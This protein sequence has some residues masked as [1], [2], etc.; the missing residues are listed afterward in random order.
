[1]NQPSSHRTGSA[2]VVALG[3]VALVAALIFAS[4]QGAVFGLQQASSGRD[5][6][7]V[8]AALEAVLAR[9]EK[10]VIE[11]AEAGDPSAF[12]E[13]T[14]NYG[15]EYFGGC[16]VRWKVEPVRSA[17]KD[18]TGSII[19][20]ISNPSP[21]I[22]WGP[23]TTLKRTAD[24]SK[25]AWLTNDTVYLFR[26]AAEAR[27][28]TDDGSNKAIEGDTLARA[29]GARYVSVNKE[30]LFRYV[31][32]YAQKG[33]KGDLELS[34]GP[35]IKIF[36]NVHSNGSIYLGA[37]TETN[38]WGAVRSERMGA[39]IIGPMDWD[40]TTAYLV[41]D[42]VRYFDSG[43]GLYTSYIAKADNTNKVPPTSSA[44]WDLVKDARV[45]VTGVDGVFRL[46][47]PPMYSFFNGFPMTN[48][49][50]WAPSS[51]TTDHYLLNAPPFSTPLD[52]LDGSL[53]TRSSAT[54]NGGF[55]N[56]YRVA[57]ASMLI[58]APA[59]A[60]STL[61]DD[62]MRRINGTAITG[63][64]SAVDSGND[65]RDK[66]RTTKLWNPT[67]LNGPPDGFS[68]FVRTRLTGGQV[69]RL[70]EMLADRPTE[71]QMVVYPDATTFTGNRLTAF[72]E[73]GDE[74]TAALP[75]FVNSDTG[76]TYTTT[77]DN[78][79]VTNTRG[80]V[81][82]PGQY[83]RYA[84]GSDDFYFR[85]NYGTDASDTRSNAPS[86]HDL[87][88]GRGFIGW[89]VTTADGTPVAASAQPSQAG[90]IIRER[91]VPDFRFFGID[92]LGGV[93]PDRTSANPDFLPYAY[94]KHKDTALWPFTEMYVSAGVN[95]NPS[96]YRTK[97]V[98]GWDPNYISNVTD[99]TRHSVQY[100]RDENLKGTC[101]ITT[102]IRR[103]GEGWGNGWT[104]NA[105]YNGNDLNSTVSVDPYGFVRDNWRF[106]HLK[107]VRSNIVDNAGPK[108]NL[109]NTSNYFAKANFTAIQ[110][111]LVSD[112]NGRFLPPADAAK[113]VYDPIAGLMVR[114]FVPTDA[115]VTASVDLATTGLNGRDPFVALCFA[116]ERG[117]VLQR[118]LVASQPVSVTIAG[119]KSYF[120]GKGTAPKADDT[121]SYHACLKLT[122]TQPTSPTYGAVAI[123]KSYT[124]S[125]MES[126]VETKN[127]GTSVTL[128]SVQLST[129]EG[130]VT[131]PS[132]S[133]VRGPWERIANYTRYKESKWRNYWPASGGT[134]GSCNW[135]LQSNA[136][137]DFQQS[138]TAAPGNA[139]WWS[140]GWNDN[141]SG[142]KF[143]VL[144]STSSFDASGNVVS[145]LWTQDI[146]SAL[147]R[148]RFINSTTYSIP[149]TWHYGG[150]NIYGAWK[151]TT[152][153]S[154]TSNGYVEA[155]H[156]SSAVI[157]TNKGSY[158]TA[159]SWYTSKGLTEAQ[160]Q[161]DIKAAFSGVT[162][163]SSLPGLTYT[164]P[165]MTL[166]DAADPVP[167]APP[168]KSA[169]VPAPPDSIQSTWNGNTYG[170]AI[171]R[172]PSNTATYKRLEVNPAI[173]ARG[174]W[175]STGVGY[176]L[177]MPTG[178]PEYLNTATGRITSLPRTYSFA[179]N[180]WTGSLTGFPAAAGATVTPAATWPAWLDTDSKTSVVY[181]SDGYN[182]GG[183]ENAAI[184]N[185]LSGNAFTNPNTR[186]SNFTN[187]ATGVTTPPLWEDTQIPRWRHSGPVYQA[188]DQGLGR[189][190][191]LVWYNGL[192]WECQTGHTPTAP[193]DQ[194][195]G[196][197][198]M[199][200]AVQR[201]FL[202]I[203]KDATGFVFKYIATAD[204]AAPAD[205]TD[206]RWRTVAPGRDSSGTIQRDA[207]DMPKTSN[208]L[209]SAD[210]PLPA[211]WS[212]YL[213]AGP[214]VQS[215][216]IVLDPSNLADTTN[217]AHCK[218]NA[219]K[220]TYAGLRVEITGDASDITGPT[221]GT[222]DGVLDYR[223][224]EA[225]A[226]PWLDSTA[227]LGNR[228]VN[229]QTSYLCSQYQVFLGPLEITED[230]FSY[231]LGDS[232]AEQDRI[233][234]EQW[235]INPRF[236][237]SQSRWWNEGDLTSSYT[238]VPRTAWVEKES[239]GLIDGGTTTSTQ[240][241]LM[242]RTT[243]LEI[244][245]AALQNYLKNRT[246]PQAAYRWTVDD[247]QGVDTTST[248]LLKSRF[249][250]LLYAARTNRYPRNP[251]PGDSVNPWNPDLPNVLS[252]SGFDTN[253]ID[254]YVGLSGG[255]ATDALA[256]SGYG[257]SYTAATSKTAV[258]DRLVA[259]NTA[260]R[261]V[262]CAPIPWED[263]H[264]GVMLTNGNSIDWGWVSSST[265]FGTGKTSI[266]TPNSLYVKGNL[267]NAM[268][269]YNVKGTTASK[270]T[271]LAIMG[272]SVTLLSSSWDYPNY[273]KVGLS[274][275]TDRCSS[276]NSTTLNQI[277]GFTAGNTSYRTCI[278][279]NNL[280]TTKY[281][282]FQG[283]GAPF[284]N[285]MLFL[286][287]WG[288]DNKGSTDRT[289]NYTGSLVVMDSCRYTRSYL[290]QQPRTFGRS[291][292]GFMGWHC[293][294]YSAL[295]GWTGGNPD[296][297]K[298]GSNQR[299]PL[300]G[301]LPPADQPYGAI[302]VYWP[303]IRNM[304]FN[305]DLLTE[306]GTP[307]NTPFGVTA[308]GVGGWT[309][310]VQ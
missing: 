62:T 80:L 77:Y 142:N 158:T 292:F 88:R 127:G 209:T 159:K 97:A 156:G 82:M 132:Y 87:G 74:H 254:L 232:K 73:R 263:F 27:L 133:F 44:Q 229:N 249:S 231:T 45:R 248:D 243:V 219:V 39:T 139:G 101:T 179:P 64:W 187:T 214:C 261:G 162:T 291:P 7:Q 223:D 190:A 38:D 91:P 57:Q 193:T 246:L 206:W 286:E 185:G 298:N 25:T 20:F 180:V 253:L 3:V 262:R 260:N 290:L 89:K 150:G 99:T 54:F 268:N 43:T 145:P 117:I 234:S 166:A 123:D 278:L 53:G 137:A 182:E 144:T 194:P 309:R 141:I 41:G 265:K 183:G 83:V 102:A 26:V 49:G 4:S 279:T 212:N 107:R 129:G 222:A 271:P 151:T 58:T 245:L 65:A 18:N 86:A 122:I 267:N 109:Q 95:A 42:R 227:T 191:S 1:M 47:K 161:N 258:R 118:R 186:A 233:A 5:Q 274:V 226:E 269:S 237:W 308:S 79:L 55:I 69:K 225:T 215:S 277:S 9:R 295:T 257:N 280:P 136:A 90:I 177:D 68:G 242:A 205:G 275:G 6:L 213:L 15:M 103:G 283:E 147:N 72:R 110:T 40:S 175:S 293:D 244:N 196:A 2:L 236:F 119:A 78:A 34:H 143:Q 176:Q 16:E 211:A 154:Q 112:G 59:T 255:S 289:M 302:N 121:S 202:R 94:G 178:W 250:G 116:P 71:A 259:A 168:A 200:K 218:D 130:L 124:N 8:Q 60:G 23:P 30:P 172:D 138:M 52:S 201:I 216:S 163:F 169:T 230:F 173:S 299:L 264:H 66:E 247:Y 114:P 11:M 140:N 160:L 22:N 307:P 203:E 238:P 239:G 305:D 272:D 303:P 240:R 198:A 306:E 197:N 310:V 98:H 189:K 108:V 33:P 61:A 146:T 181:R 284:I 70:P 220:A 276:F 29:Q 153:A 199:W 155:T 157:Y 56:P 149:Y 31:I 241:Q 296:W 105:S 75:A 111:E 252:S 235:F 76:A 81:E 256:A 48:A 273:R 13:W 10:R 170:V 174:S 224:W 208:A 63:N 184:T 288:D 12:A 134:T 131:R 36:G 17:P 19:P 46:A 270:W 228:L 192:I 14:D 113:P 84:L 126:R 128:P 285:T 297:C 125:V 148:N 37:G 24:T 164:S 32:F 251:T 282:T 294:D 221:A 217:W 92:A 93:L 301:A 210:T 266:V 67:S 152:G 35:K 50:S 188:A 21:D 135:V 104:T 106:L 96:T 204:G 281:R 171:L 207:D 165:T 85:R 28:C 287:D 300:S 51:P 115:S 304:T 195:S 100:Q 167:A 120:T